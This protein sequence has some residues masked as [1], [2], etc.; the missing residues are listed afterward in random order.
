MLCGQDIGD[1]RRVADVLAGTTRTLASDCGAMVVKLQRDADDLETPLDQQSRGY[2]R[3]DAARHR[4]NDAVVGRVS[5]EV[6]F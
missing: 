4:D 3:I 6:G 1:A 2:R 5:G